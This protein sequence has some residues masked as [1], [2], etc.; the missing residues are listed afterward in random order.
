MEKHSDYTKSIPEYIKEEKYTDFE[1]EYGIYSIPA[2][3][4]GKGSS[5]SVEDKVVPME[6]TTVEFVIIVDESKNG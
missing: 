2:P 4:F 5:L 6:D 1:R 3:K